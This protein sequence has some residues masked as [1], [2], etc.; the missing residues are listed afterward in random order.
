MGCEVTTH[1]ISVLPAHNHLE[2]NEVQAILL[3]GFH[4]K[5]WQLFVKK[6]HS[7]TVAA[8]GIQYNDAK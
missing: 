6:C 7:L 4:H 1:N 3:V 5:V 2:Y 8:Q